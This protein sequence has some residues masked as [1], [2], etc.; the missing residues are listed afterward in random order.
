MTA[1]PTMLAFAQEYLAFRRALGFTLGT[2]GQE[3]LLFARWADRIGHS[4]PLTTELMVRWAQQTP[5]RSP[6]YWAW[7][8]HAVRLFARHRALSD[9]QTEVPPAGLL[10]PTF[11]RACPHIYSSAEITALLAAART[12]RRGLRP[13]TYVAVFGLL[14]ATGLRVGEALALHHADVDLEQGLLTI[15]KAKAGQSRLVPLHPSTT[16]ALRYYVKVRDRVHV[17]RQTEAFFVTVRGT[18]LTYQWVTKTF[19]TLRRQLGWATTPRAA[20]RVHDFRHTFAVRALLHWYEAGVDIDAHI[21]TLAT[22]L[23]HVNVTD[24]YWYLTAVPELMAIGASRFEM[25]AESGGRS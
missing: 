22:Y 6:A 17:R 25:F 21:A 9:P 11:R 2:L 15:R 10:G 23:G 24:T 8:F 1:A 16:E 14:I 4:G 3:V 18:A 13:H 12:L 20:P 5:Q 19:R 7:R